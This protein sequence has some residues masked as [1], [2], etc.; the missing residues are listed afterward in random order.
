MSGI[1]PGAPDLDAFWDNLLAG[2]DSIGEI[3]AE[4]WNWR[5]YWGDAATEPGRTKVKWGG[6]IEGAGDFDPAFFGISIPEAR[7]MDPQQRIL[8]LQAW[9][10]IEDA[11]YAPASLA[12]SRLGVFVG[13]AD[14]G[15]GR[16]VAQSGAKLEGYS[17]TGLAPSLGPNRIS[18][19]LD[20][21]GPS[22][23][24]ETACSSSLVAIHRALESMRRGDC[25]TALAGG[26]N[27]LLHADSFVGFS[28]AGMLS[29]DGRSKTFSAQ[30]NGYARGEGA[31][32]IFLK[33]LADAERDGDR[34]LA[35]IRA[36]A[37]NHGGHASSL[38]APNPKAQAALLR[39]VYG[40]AGFDPRTV[41][42]I[43]A[44]GTGTALG[45]PIEVEALTSA[46]AALSRE[47]QAEYGELPALRCGLGSVKSNIG[48]L[49]LAAGIAG[50]LKVLLQFRHGT[51]VKSLHCDELNPYLKLDG[52]RFE[53]V[54]ETR[55][56]TRPADAQGRELPRRAGV[57][58]FGFGGSNAHVVLEEYIAAPARPHAAPHS[59]RPALIVLSAA[60]AETLVK[61]AAQLRDWLAQ[62]DAPAHPA[63]GASLD[64]IAYTL[65]VGRSPMEHRLAFAAASIDELA[66]RL[67]A[68]CAGRD[69]DGVHA[70]RVKPHRDTL[71]ILDA[72]DEVRRSLASLA[73]RG[74]HD[75]LLKMWVRG[76][77]VAWRE[78]HDG[79]APRRIA[80]PGYP[81][82]L[83]RYWVTAAPSGAVP[84]GLAPVAAEAPRAPA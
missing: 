29:P 65:Q 26:I 35:V 22:L 73:L 60:S 71:A 53:V 28:R 11:G 12:G 1:L 57:S 24:V 37:E 20:V 4:R 66:R 41:G 21:H 6:F 68:F 36:S 83:A 76:L 54:R 44:H 74:K 10:A 78:L 45:D 42:Y 50:V 19:F 75:S 63:H 18:F 3:P 43:E 38:T 72:D 7:M 64:E 15:Y 16:L 56:W 69:D 61:A 55:A 14:T 34:I 40:R 32:L 46:F 33:R 30:A 23:A 59:G 31:G 17:M 77:P 39:T 70:A 84:H 27:L 48:H 8:L 49:E 52:S 47:A 81:F 82:N 58:S 51:L 13:T 5:D 67:D 9:R 2:R 79:A 25:D 62:R 80:L